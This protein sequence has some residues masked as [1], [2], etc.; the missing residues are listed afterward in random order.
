[1]VNIK[2]L[3]TNTLSHGQVGRFK[4]IFCQGIGEHLCVMNLSFLTLEFYFLEISYTKQT[5]V[6]EKKRYA[7]VIYFGGDAKL[8]RDI[9]KARNIFYV[10][11]PVQHWTDSSLEAHLCKNDGY[12]NLLGV[13]IYIKVRNVHRFKLYR[14]LE[15]KVEDQIS[16]VD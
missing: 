16:R 15:I 14:Q 2:F 5:S 12:K 7:R 6:R 11:K 8:R 4:R 1:M 3:I 10:R 9:T 13:L